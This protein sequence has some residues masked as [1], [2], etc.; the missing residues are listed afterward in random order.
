MLSACGDRSLPLVHHSA[1]CFYFYFLLD[2]WAHYGILKNV[3]PLKLVL[4]GWGEGG[5]GAYEA[6][7]ITLLS[8]VSI[9][10]SPVF[11]LLFVLCFQFEFIAADVN[12][13]ARARAC[14]SMCVC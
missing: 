9:K 13:R 4:G 14:V 6:L 3:V 7:R 2:Q 11:V 10:S 8:L 1:A 12:F 5:G